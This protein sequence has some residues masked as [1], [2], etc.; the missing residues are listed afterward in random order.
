MNA[1]KRNFV[2]LLFALAGLL[3]LGLGLAKAYF[4]DEPINGALIVVAC[5]FFVFAL[6]FRGVSRK[7]V[8]RSD[9]PSV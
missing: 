2:A 6:V 3:A 5:M 1:G 7:P 9:L 4:K 8:N